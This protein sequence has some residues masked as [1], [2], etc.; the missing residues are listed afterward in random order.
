MNL[1]MDY[2]QVQQGIHI[3]YGALILDLATNPDRLAALKAKLAE[4]RLTTPLFDTRQY[5][6]D[7]EQALVHAYKDKVG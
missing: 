7:F 3:P 2:R 4:N 5:T 1:E 6:R